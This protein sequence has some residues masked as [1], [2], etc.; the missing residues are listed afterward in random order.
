MN[1]LW[2]D[3]RYLIVLSSDASHVGRDSLEVLPR[4]AVTDVARA[5][6]LLDL[7]RDLPVRNVR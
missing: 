4:L 1:A 3:W 6:N 7:A 5:D 2:S